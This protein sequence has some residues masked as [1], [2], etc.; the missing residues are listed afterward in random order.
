MT[1][2]RVP[3]TPTGGPPGQHIERLGAAH[4]DRAAVRPGHR[5]MGMGVHLLRTMTD[6][7]RH[8]VRPDG[9]NELTLV[10]SIDN[11]AKEA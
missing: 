1:R 8:H 4:W 9:G 2:H 3:G 11:P 10:R 6:A 5:G 7:V